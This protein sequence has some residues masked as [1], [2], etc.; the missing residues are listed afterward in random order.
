M[1]IVLYLFL[2]ITGAIYAGREIQDEDIAWELFNDIKCKV[3]IIRMQLD[4]GVKLADAACIPLAQRLEQF[5][6]FDV[7]WTEF[8]NTKKYFVNNLHDI[9]KK[10]CFT[11]FSD[12]M[13]NDKWRYDKERK[14]L[15]LQYQ[16][17]RLLR[18]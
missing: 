13:R 17:I 12:I 14:G 8:E 5:E 18:R 10:K 15:A 3:Y 9:D 4:F 2:C 1:K 16:N 6:K 11:E 7:L